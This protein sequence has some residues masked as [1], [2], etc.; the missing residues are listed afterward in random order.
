MMRKNLQ[1]CACAAMSLLGCSVALGTP[2]VQA[3]QY[4][5]TGTT[6]IDTTTWENPA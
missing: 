6:P 5:A 3:F 4:G 1:W 2:L